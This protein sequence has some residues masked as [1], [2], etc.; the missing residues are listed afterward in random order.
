VCVCFS[1]HH[2]ALTPPQSQ[3]RETKGPGLSPFS[4]NFDFKT[5]VDI[6]RL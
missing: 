4:F 5:V 3:K 2:L 1:S 6:V